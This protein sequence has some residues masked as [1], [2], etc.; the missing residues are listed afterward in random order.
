MVFTY[1]ID[2]LLP[3]DKINAGP[4]PPR[5]VFISDKHYFEIDNKVPLS[6]VPRLHPLDGR[7]FLFRWI[8]N[9]YSLSRKG[10]FLRGRNFVFA[11]K[12]FP[13]DKKYSRN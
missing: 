10:I 2:I 11:F 13:S 9:F 8:H 1:D 3:Y 4:N 7:K 6:A 5:N 12:A